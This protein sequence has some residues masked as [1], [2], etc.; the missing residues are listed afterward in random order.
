MKDKK[1]TPSIKKW[2]LR[3]AVMGCVF[4]LLS[5]SCNWYVDSSSSKYISNEIKDIPFNE[6]GLLPGTSKYFAKNDKNTFYQARINAAFLLYKFKKVNKI[7][8]SGTAEKYYNEPK[9]LRADLRK[10]GIPDSVI[11][12]DTNGIHTLQSIN[13]LKAMNVDSVTIISQFSHLQRAV[14]LGRKAHVTAYGYIAA[15]PVEENKRV[16]IREYFAKIKA[17]WDS[18]FTL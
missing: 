10:L 18:W 3:L 5:F 13:F 12:S 17:V 6:Y 14:F 16:T 2:L 15:D 8:V 7:I 9:Q 1:R 11:I 4:F